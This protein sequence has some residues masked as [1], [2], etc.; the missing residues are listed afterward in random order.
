MSKTHFRQVYKSDHLGVADL[1]DYLEQGKPLIFVIKEV[2]QEKNALVAGNRGDFNIAYFTDSTVKPLVLNAGNAKIVKSFANNSSYL[3]DW[4]NIPVELYIDSNV[5]M[6]GQIVEG[7]RIKPV[8]PTITK[9][10]PAFTEVHFD[11]ALANKATIERIKASYT[12]T[13]EIEAK[14]L[15]RLNGTA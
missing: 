15:K 4:K 13:P 11:K 14:Y 9:S 10:I 12:I 3:E 1:E 8:K 2:K 7:V 5:K 6:K